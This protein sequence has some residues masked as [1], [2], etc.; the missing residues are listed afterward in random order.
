[1]DVADEYQNLSWWI[2][3]WHEDTKGI[4]RVANLALLKQ[5]LEADGAVPE[6]ASGQP[7]TE[8]EDEAFLHREALL[9]DAVLKERAVNLA[10]HGILLRVYADV[11]DW[12]NKLARLLLRTHRSMNL[13]PKDFSG[14]GITRSRLIITKFS[15][16][17]DSKKHWERL[18]LYAAIRNS[19]PHRSGHVELTAEYRERQEDIEPLSD[20]EASTPP[21]VSD[22]GDP[23]LREAM[24]KLDHVSLSGGAEI[25]INYLALEDLADCA[26]EYLFHFMNQWLDRTQVS[27][28]VWAD[29]Q[30]YDD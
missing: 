8:E 25:V 6:K 11:E 15:V 7:E 27:R 19:I 26:R 5:S 9:D 22:I 20:G 21:Q 28:D 12:M 23:R 30:P 18:R 2:N 4:I 13:G 1:M 3:E 10:N 29:R 24:H 17:E 14:S 16:L